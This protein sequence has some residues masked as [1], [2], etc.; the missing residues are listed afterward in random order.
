[1]K[2]INRILVELEF[3]EEVPEVY[4]RFKTSEEF[5]QDLIELIADECSVDDVILKYDIKEH[6]QTVTD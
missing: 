5:S 1:M 6:V 3:I 2:V 4:E